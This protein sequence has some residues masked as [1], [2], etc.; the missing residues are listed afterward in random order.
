[1]MKNKAIYMLKELDELH[2][3]SI[4]AGDKLKRFYP[5]QQ[6]QL[7]HALN[8]NYKKLLNLDNLFLNNGNS[9]FFDV[10]DNI[11]DL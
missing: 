2:L 11:C 5:R 8:L 4:F 9:N 10:P 7:G 6:L 3:S 1:M